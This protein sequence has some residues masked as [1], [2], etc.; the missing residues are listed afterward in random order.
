MIKTNSMNTVV[1]NNLQ[2]NQKIDRIS[3]EILENNYNDA[4]FSIIGI[5][6]NGHLLAMK[7]ANKLKL[8]SEK[9]I[10]LIELSINKNDPFKNE[11]LLSAEISDSSNTLILVDDVVNSGKTMQYALL[12]LL[13]FPVNKVRTVALVDRKHRRYPIRCDYVGITLSTTLKDRVEV[14]LNE[15]DCQAYLV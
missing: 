1:L 4:S 13:E 11:I 5:R 15:N 6:G 7:I 2:I 3:Y 12:K 8:I 9:R 10:E 14:S